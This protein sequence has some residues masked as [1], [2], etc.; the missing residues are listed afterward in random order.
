MPDRYE[1]SVWAEGQ[2]F[3]ADGNPLDAQ[4][5]PIPIEPQSSEDNPTTTTE[6]N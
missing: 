4:G 6:E 3:D 2:A 5:N 1:F